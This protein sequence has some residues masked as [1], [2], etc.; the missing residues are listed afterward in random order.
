M[1]DSWNHQTAVWLRFYVFERVK[2]IPS[3]ASYSTLITFLVSAF[4][5]GFYPMYYIAFFFCSLT[6][7]ATRD[8]YKIRHHFSWLPQ[9]AIYIILH[10]CASQ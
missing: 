9:L 2:V 3:V 5:H 10:I 7:E 4:W 6:V 1:I 8:I